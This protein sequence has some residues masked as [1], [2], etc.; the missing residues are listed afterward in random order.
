MSWLEALGGVEGWREKKER[1]DQSKDESSGLV[2]KK[3][4][5]GRKERRK[6]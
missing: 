2:E 5:E 1:G 4:E 6:F 3:A